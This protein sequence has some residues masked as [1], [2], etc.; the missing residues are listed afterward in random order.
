M[1]GPFIFEGTLTADKYGE[2][3]QD[4]LSVFLDNCVSFRDLSQLWFKHDGAAAHESLASCA[5]L[6]TFGNNIIEHGCHAE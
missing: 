5:V 2:I 4:P 6:T 3:L 1:S